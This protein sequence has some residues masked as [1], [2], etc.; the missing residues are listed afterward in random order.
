MQEDALALV[1]KVKAELQSQIQA[2][3]KVKGS[4]LSNSNSIL[5]AQAKSKLR[6]QIENYLIELNEEIYTISEELA[7]VYSTPTNS[8]K[9]DIAKK[10]REFERRKNLLIKRVKKT[11]QEGSASGLAAFTGGSIRSR[12]TSPALNSRPRS[13]NSK[14]RA[15][16]PLRTRRSLTRSPQNTAG[17]EDNKGNTGLVVM[18]MT[19][20][21][22]NVSKPP[23]RGTSIDSASNCLAV[24]REDYFQTSFIDTEVHQST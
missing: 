8:A 24:T 16:H 13:A 20:R 3:Q 4:V 11:I 22:L 23:A 10:A 17:G 6:I 21:C 9:S 7:R 19:P 2:L 15:G 18:N 12:S 14:P 5:E 1:E